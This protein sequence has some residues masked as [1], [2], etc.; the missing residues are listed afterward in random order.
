MSLRP[1]LEN[2][3][4]RFFLSV[5]S[6]KRK[7]IFFLGLGASAFFCSRA[8]AGFYLTPGEAGAEFLTLPISARST[9]LG[10]GLSGVSGDFHAYEYNPAALS[11]LKDYQLTFTRSLLY[12][13]TNITSFGIGLEAHK[14]IGFGIQYRRFGGSDAARDSSGFETG[15]DVGIAD[16]GV[17]AGLSYLFWKRIS[18]GYAVEHVQRNIYTHTVNALNHHAGIQAYFF[19]GR[20]I[21]GLSAQ[22][23]GNPININQDVDEKMPITLRFGGSHKIGREIFYDRGFKTSSDPAFLAVWELTQFRDRKTLGFSGGLEWRIFPAMALRLGGQYRENFQ[24]K[25]GF[26]FRWKYYDIDYSV[27]NREELG[28]A[29]TFSILFRWGKEDEEFEGDDPF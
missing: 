4:T 11:S 19:G 9:A 17:S 23:L 10:G 26:G 13:G 21:L 1:R 2:Q 28:L 5:K 29:H 7:L 25:S 16:N 18:V 24:I 12:L 6:L 22:N 20:H 15:T 3:G 27:Q 14:N 8:F